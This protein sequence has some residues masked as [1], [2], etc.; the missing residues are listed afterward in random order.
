MFAETC[1]PVR[2]VHAWPD[3]PHKRLTLPRQVDFRFPAALD[4]SIARTGSEGVY[5]T[6]DLFTDSCRIPH[7]QSSRRVFPGQVR[8]NFSLPGALP[9]SEHGNIAGLPG[10]NR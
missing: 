3:R 4:F 6:F 8:A 2:Q 5:E 10:R 1:S 9:P 7:L